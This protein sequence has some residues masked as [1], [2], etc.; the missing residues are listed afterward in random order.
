MKKYLLGFLRYL[1]HLKVS[2]MA[3]V[4]QDSEI[5]RKAAVYRFAKIYKSFIGDYSYIGPSSSIV[6]A[7]IGKYCSIASNVNIGLASH[8][9]S[10]ISTSPIFTE[11]RNGTKTSWV[12]QNINEAK[13]GKCIIGNDVWIGTK[14][15]IMDGLTIGDGAIIG[16]G[17][18]VTHDVPS[19][20]I[21]AG[22]PAKVI[23]YRF[24]AQVIESMMQLS[25]W[26]LPESIVR[27]NISLFQTE[28]IDISA[29]K[30]M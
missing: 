30:T 8:T 9:F 11:H 1:F 25:W 26:D 10:Y 15:I 16:A 20:A 29:M 24:D 17:S 3:L 13:I 7:K 12:K 18:I 2:K 28:N 14:V 6:C 4:T 27:N 5:S 23:R 21:V 19:Y 22:I